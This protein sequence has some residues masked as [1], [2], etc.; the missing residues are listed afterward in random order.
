DSYATG[1]HSQAN[2]TLVNQT[3]SDVR[4]LR[5]RVRVYDLQGRVRDDKTSANLDVA[6]GGTAAAMT[7]PREARDSRVFFIR[8]EVLDPSGK[9]VDQNV[10]WQSQR[11]DDVGDP[12]GDFAFELH[13]DSFADMTPLNSMPKVPLQVTARRSSPG[14]DAKDGITISL[15][16]PSKQVAFFERAEVTSTEDGD[17]L[18]PSEYDDNYVTVF[19]G[20]TVDIRASVPRAS[21]NSGSADWV[22]VTGYNSAPVVVPVS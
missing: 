4:D 12:D 14:Q 20:E 18:L 21:S 3:P 10:Y 5:V 13:Q 16:N 15:R 8:C 7:I 9:V 1:D 22:R 11:N 2:I 19:P 6:S 17:E